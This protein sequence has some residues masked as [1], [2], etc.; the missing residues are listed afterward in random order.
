MQQKRCVQDKL[1]TTLYQRRLGE[2]C[3]EL[4]KKR[5]SFLPMLGWTDD[6]LVLVD[7]L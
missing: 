6:D 2:L 5:I 3:S 7:K 4:C 1:D